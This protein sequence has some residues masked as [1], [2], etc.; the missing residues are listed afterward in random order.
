MADTESNGRDL[1][2][3]MVE[4]SVEEI[5]AI[6][7]G[8]ALLIVEDDEVVSRMLV[9][10]L[11]ASFKSVTVA[12]SCDAGLSEMKTKK[13]DVIL[14]DWDCPKA[15]DG[16]RIIGFA[17]SL[18]TPVVVCTG[19]STAEVPPGVIVIH[20]PADISEIRNAL[21]DAWIL[22]NAKIGGDER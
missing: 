2:M 17:K 15:G 6:G 1:A 13:Y 12:L 11:K 20:K 22:M 10:V 18:S 9:R 16:I 5:K 7:K 4:S 19:N 14:S 8:L 21:V 3:L